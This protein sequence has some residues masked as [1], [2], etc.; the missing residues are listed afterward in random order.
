[1]ISLFFVPW[2]TLHTQGSDVVFNVGT[3][4]LSISAM[5]A[6]DAAVSAD[7]A[8]LKDVSLN[9]NSMQ[10]GHRCLSSTDI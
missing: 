1:M 9:A 3:D 5:A 10:D 8:E 7:V 4:Q 2:N 6:L